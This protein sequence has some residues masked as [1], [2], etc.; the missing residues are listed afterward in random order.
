MPLLMDSCSSP[1]A[2]FVLVCLCLRGSDEDSSQAE[3]DFFLAYEPI[4]GRPTDWSQN[5]IYFHY[6]DVSGQSRTNWK[7]GQVLKREAAARRA[8]EEK[9]YIE[10]LRRINERR[11]AAF[12]GLNLEVTKEELIRRDQAQYLTS[13][14]EHTDATITY[15]QVW[16]IMPCSTNVHCL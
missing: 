11:H 5:A 7:H 6:H 3:H 2:F 9:A 8:A 14:L 15:L 13:E 10:K 4:N 12:L 1:H 16:S